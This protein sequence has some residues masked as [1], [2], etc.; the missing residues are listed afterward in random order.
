MSVGGSAGVS[1]S[2]FQASARPLSVNGQQAGSGAAD[3][4]H[5]V[6]NNAEISFEE[7]I[8]IVEHPLDLDEILSEEPTSG[9][10]LEEL[11]LSEETEG[12]ARSPTSRSITPDPHNT[13]G[14]I[15]KQT[16]LKGVANQLSQATTHSEAGLPTALAVGLQ[17]IAVGTSHGLVLVF[18]TEEQLRSVLSPYQKAGQEVDM[19]QYGAVST[20][21]LSADGTRLLCGH[22]KGLITHWDLSNGKCLRF[23]DDAHPAGFGVLSVKFTEDPNFVLFIN[24]G[25]NL[26]SIKFKRTLTRSW[27]PDCLFSGCHGEALTFEPLLLEHKE[28]SFLADMSI[29]AVATVTQV[30]IL[31]IQPELRGLTALPLRGKPQCLPQLAWQNVFIEVKSGNKRTVRLRPVL[32][33]AKGNKIYYIQ[34]YY[35]DDG[36]KFKL[37]RKFEVS[38]EVASFRWINPHTVVAMDTTERIHLISVKDDQEI[39]VLDLKKVE[40]VYSSSFFKAIETG[41]NVSKALMAA[42][43]HACYSS[44]LSHQNKLLL[45]GLKAVHVVSIKPWK[46]RLGRLVREGKVVDA[47]KLGLNIYDG[48]APA[49][50]GLQGPPKKKKEIV[51]EQV[52]DILLGYIDLGVMMQKPSS[53]REKDLKEHYKTL[54]R[55]GFLCCLKIKRLDLLFGTIYDT[56]SA[57]DDLS[58]AVFLEHLCT[59]ITTSRL[60]FIRTVVSKDFIDYY[61]QR[62]E[63]KLL[64]SCILQLNPK[65]LDIHQVVEMCWS[66]QLYDAMIHVYNCGMHDYT[67]P[68]LEL[69][70]QLR[71][72]LKKGTPISDM[73]LSIGNK[74]LV[75]TRCCLAGLAYPKGNIPQEQVVQAKVDVYSVL[76]APTNTHNP[77]DKDSYPHVRTLLH[78]DTRGFLNVIAL[79][80][81]EQDL[82]EAFT[83]TAPKGI[84][85]RQQVVDILL[86]VMVHEFSFSPSQVGS[87]FT[88][89]A[90]QGAKHRASIR[91]DEHVYDQVLDYITDA[92]EDIVNEERQQALLELWNAGVLRKFD[93]DKLLM[94]AE[95]AKFFRLCELLY[96][97]RRQFAKV[98]SC[99]IRDNNRRQQC[100]SYV[101]AVMNEDL[102]TEPDREEVARAVLQNFK[103]LVDHDVEATARLILSDFPLELAEVT[104]KLHSDPAQEFQFLH[105]IFDPRSQTKQELAPPLHVVERY[106]EL[107]CRYKPE[108][109]YMFLKSSDNY[110][111]EEALEVCSKASI[112][113]ATAYLLERSGDIMGAF[114]LILETL[115]TEVDVVSEQYYIQESV[116][117]EMGERLSRVEGILHTLI[118]FCQRNS[119]SVD[120]RERQ[121][122]WFPIF[123]KI[124]NMQQKYQ[125]STNMRLT[126]LYTVMIHEVLN[127]MLGY[128]SLPD[129]L[130]KIIQ[131][132][133]YQF[134]DIK[135]LIMGMLEKYN[136]EET[137]LKTTH[138]IM[139]HDVRGSLSYLRSLVQKAITPHSCFCVICSRG[140]EFLADGSKDDVTVFQCGHLYHTSCLGLSG[141]TGQSLA[142]CCIVCNKTAAP[143]PL[144]SRLTMDS[145]P[146][147]RSLAATSKKSGHDEIQLDS[148]QR[149]N[150]KRFHNSYCSRP[151]IMEESI[152]LRL[153]PPKLSGL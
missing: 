23:I 46:E 7:D 73:Y 151:E 131:D 105:V 28:E 115:N 112:I 39:E 107:L 14:A 79:A 138:H 121:A 87:L 21:D 52:I 136:Y 9:F 18:N 41:G 113:D 106:I 76:L 104:Y 98:L 67:T 61:A 123:D 124:H 35:G 83:G 86:K 135:Q 129:I 122:M 33:I 51:A 29:L 103:V 3:Q 102:Y 127:S 119:T 150:L 139:V 108:E 133:S 4:L 148:I 130:Q 80:F 143:K 88:F 126:E 82:D 65:C 16:V 120:E 8:P 128:V 145:G 91:V 38:Y 56:F 44:V 74:V 5:S 69:L 77:T 97:K 109:V 13:E 54:A 64:E 47:L 32:A 25:G 10:S 96:E 34:S 71:G 125:R 153:A 149:E 30:M 137:L 45:L 59:Y 134:K 43:G 72:T 142:A 89:L 60:T 15:L 100:F 27:V 75:Y 19:G 40:L 24:T 49:V 140:A 62:K 42:S 53:G 99:Y 70:L 50:I 12:R 132:P 114:K 141:A 31:S 147:G 11:G 117:I 68:L 94:K 93:E 92:E 90:R 84:P 37:L 116:D 2:F 78:F 26:F 66:Q 22:A 48:C 57:E 55:W 144:P 36:P 110:R 118:Q 95:T 1:E 111:L 6:L 81:E 101:R 20:L 85:T 17:H 146:G 58:K 152:Q 63:Y